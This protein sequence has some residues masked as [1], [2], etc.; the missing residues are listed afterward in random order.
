MSLR[1]FALLL[2][3][4]SL[5]AQ[6]PLPPVLSKVFGAASIR[7]GVSTPL[8]FTL[9]NPNSNPTFTNLGFSDTLPA[10]L[11]ISGV[12]LGGP[13]SCDQ[14]PTTVIVS[15]A[16]FSISGFALAPGASC[17]LD[18]QV[19]G[20]SPGVQNNVTSTVTDDQGVVG[21]AAMASIT[22]LP[23]VPP[24]LTKVFGAATIQVGDETSLTF[25]LTNPSTN[26]NNPTFTNLAFS[27]TLPAGLEISGVNLG[28]PGS[29]DQ[30]A[31]TVVISSASF[32]ITGFALAAGASCTLNFQ[33]QGLTGGVQH[34]VTSSVTDDQGVTGMAAEA[35]ITVLPPPIISKS[36]ADSQ[37]QLF[38]PG[39]TTALSFTITNPNPVT[40]NDIAFTDTLPS[41]LIVSTPNDLTGSC[42]GGTITAV[43][44]SSSISLSGATL[45]TGASC[46][47]SVNVSAT[48]LG[49]QVNTTSAVTAGGGKVV[50]NSA[51]ASISIVHSFFNW[52][53]SESGGGQP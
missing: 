32:S 44:G 31:T 17:T 18:F 34:N 15:T 19:Q 36:F 23:V 29:C 25:T 14:G 9:T 38:G 12:S 3:S 1:P 28:G 33:V 42:G 50:G 39:N 52:F 24:M 40:F 49:V 2:L 6:Q 30:G 47:F 53:F 22:V 4:A 8:T 21:P 46:T 26:P 51:T 48:A 20:V 43:A 27:D 45:A 35:D 41:G 16:S 7:V 11:E 5:F 10:G 37:L 13:G